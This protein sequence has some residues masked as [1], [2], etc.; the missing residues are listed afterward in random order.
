MPSAMLPWLRANVLLNAGGGGIT[1][2][3]WERP[4]AP[5]PP[6]SPKKPADLSALVSPPCRMGR[7]IKDFSCRRREEARKHKSGM[8]MKAQMQ[9]P[10]AILVTTVTPNPSSP[11]AFLPGTSDTQSLPRL[12]LVS[13]GAPSSSPPWREETTGRF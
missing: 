8:V 10:P 13:V 12:Q 3:C 5:W 11:P 2:H 6:P 4:L 7:A 1:C 9:T